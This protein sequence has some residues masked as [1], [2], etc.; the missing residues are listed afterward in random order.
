M[1]ISDYFLYNEK[2]NYKKYLFSAL[3]FFLPFYCNA[4]GVLTHEAIIDGL[5]E[6]SILPLLKAKYPSS[7]VEE[8]KEAH[9]YAYGGAVAPDM[10][11]YP[12]GSALFTNLVHYVRSGDMVEALLKDANTINQ[13]AFAIGFMSHYY[14]DNYGHPIATNRSVPLVYPNLRKKYGSVITYAENKISHMR[15]E[16]GFDVLEVSKGNYTSDKYH[17]VIG[18]KVDTT[19]LSKAFFETYGL[20]VNDVFNHKF[21]LAVEVFRWTVANV[22][23]FITKAAWSSKS[24][25]ILKKDSTLSSKTFRYKMRQKQYNQDF[26]T[27][28]KHPG[29]FPSV[30]SFFIRIL[31]K[32]GPL[33]PLKFKTPTALAE[34]YFVQSFD[35]ITLH[36]SAGLKRLNTGI[37]L[38]DFDFDT[39][40]P[41]AICEYS[42][43]DITYDSWLMQLKND[44]FKNLS[45]NMKQNIVGFYHW[46]DA[47]NNILYTKNCRKVFDAY[48]EIQNSNPGK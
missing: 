17:G 48:K 6:K 1:F 33:R 10:G 12:F 34:K 7:T 4:F 23:P 39:G 45:L 26:G 25:D 37:N 14:A 9:A 16:F 5:W 8:Q 44:K 11:F 19:V 42:L 24:T 28:Y 47:S 46:Q 35:S 30:L 43:A 2:K 22:F 29:F 31:P 20:D 15:M 18:F 40:K 13:Y 27:A 32:V 21:L 3:I 41:T 36:Y 38:K